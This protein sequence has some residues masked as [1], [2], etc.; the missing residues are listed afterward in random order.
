LIKRRS[1]LIGLGATLAAP[2]VVR[3]KSL[4]R[5]ATPKLVPVQRRMATPDQIAG[6]VLGVDGDSA[7]VYGGGMSSGLSSCGYEIIPRW[8]IAQGPISIGDVVTRDAHS[9][10]LRRAVVA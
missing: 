6:V 1:F 3:A 4:M 9:G 2:A 10:R 7:L 8:E 5:I